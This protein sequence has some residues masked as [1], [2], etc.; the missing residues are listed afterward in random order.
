MVFFF[1]FAQ[2]GEAAPASDDRSSADKASYQIVGGTPVP[3]GKY[4]FMAAVI[5]TSIG[6][7]QTVASG[8]NFGQSHQLFCGGTLIDTDSVLT[9]GH[10]FFD[11]N[12]GAP[13]PESIKLLQVIIGRTL[14]TTNQGQT[15]DIKSVFIHPYF[16]PKGFAQGS[17]TA[18]SYD[19]AMVELSSPV[20]G[21][22]PIKLATASQNYLETPGRNGTVAGWG[23]TSALPA[24]KS[25]EE[26]SV[27]PDRIR[28]AQVPIVS[29]AR[30]EQVYQDICPSN[31][32]RDMYVPPLMVAAGGTDVDTCKGD[33][34]GP[35]FVRTSGNDENSAEYMQIGI[36]S[37]S[38]ACAHNGYPSAY[39]EV[40]ASPIA[41]FIKWAASK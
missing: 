17:P 19:V 16:N 4:P 33:S 26:P 23:I 20:S 37:F 12:T 9:A 15:R 29:D 41:S 8:M 27:R 28:E 35:L 5:D 32:T 14:L 30:A 21:I 34:G 6:E 31:R 11:P 36:T 10:C 38:A 3:D 1:V 24:C 2:S 18:F 25:K 40:N 13:E 7:S 39:T 22:T